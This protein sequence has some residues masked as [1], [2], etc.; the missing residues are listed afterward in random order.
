[1][2]ALFSVIMS[3]IGLS[4]QHAGLQCLW[5]NLFSSVLQLLL[6]IF[7]SLN[8]TCRFGPRETPFVH[9]PVCL[10]VCVSTFWTGLARRVI[11]YTLILG[12]LW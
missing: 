3:C 4:A 6:W 9:V 7:E 2:Q 5:H 12:D 1:M 8:V 10:S 11:F